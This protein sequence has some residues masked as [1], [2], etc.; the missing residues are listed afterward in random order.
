VQTRLAAVRTHERSKEPAAIEHGCHPRR[1]ELCPARAEMQLPIDARRRLRL[2]RQ[3]GGAV[4]KF[5]LDLV[6]GIFQTPHLVFNFGP[7][8]FQKPRIQ[9]LSEL[10]TS[11]LID[12]RPQM[13]MVLADFSDH[14]RERG[15][16]VLR[17]S[18][19]RGSLDCSERR[20]SNFRRSAW[21]LRPRLRRQC[22]LRIHLRLR[23]RHEQ[24]PLAS[25]LSPL[26]ALLQAG[27][28][29]TRAHQM[30]GIPRA[31]HNEIS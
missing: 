12:K 7:G 27:A 5:R 29:S 30:V 20:R 15:I 24:L 22:W 6:D 25:H 26:L 10:D 14:L 3:H 9:L 13:R 31:R 21:M 16:V 17:G 11:E 1:T 2:K 8:T 28:C 23:Q 4:C 18:V 19:L